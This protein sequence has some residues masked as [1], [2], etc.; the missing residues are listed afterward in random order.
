MEELLTFSSILDTD[1]PYANVKESRFGALGNGIRDDTASFQEALDT[2]G[3]AGGGFI[4]IPRGQYRVSQLIIS[5][6]NIGIVGETG[7]E[8]LSSAT[9]EAFRVQGDV[10]NIYFAHFTI[11]GTYANTD[12]K[13]ITLA[14][15]TDVLIEHM[16]I[17]DC[18]DAGIYAA[19]TYTVQR[20]TVRDN[21]I[22]HCGDF[23]VVL[24]SD[25]T[26][27]LVSDVVVSGNHLTN[28]AST[29][30][31]AHGV[32]YKGVYRGVISD[33]V[34]R[35]CLGANAS[36]IIAWE[37]CQDVTIKDNVCEGNF[38]GILIAGPTTEG[39]IVEGNT[40]RNTIG[41]RDAILVQDE[42]ENIIVA[43]NVLSGG[44]VS[45]RGI[46]VNS[47]TVR[48]QKVIVRGNTIADMIGGAIRVDLSDD[49]LVQ[50]NIIDQTGDT[51]TFSV[52]VSDST[53]VDISH[54]R[55]KGG[56]RCIMVSGATTLRS[57]VDYNKISGG[58]VWG[59]RIDP[60]VPSAQCSLIGNDGR[61]FVGT[62]SAAIDPGGAA[63]Q[64]IGNRLPSGYSVNLASAAT[65][66]LPNVV[67]IVHVTGTTP[68]TNITISW[69][70]RRVTLK[71]AT[72]AANMVV[73][74][75]NLKMAGNF[76]PDADDTITFVSEGSNWWEVSRSIN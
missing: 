46:V 3:D 42:V 47:L 57:S 15:A 7:A 72:G 53:D 31:P 49:V 52:Y 61:G 43:D 59:I 21:F 34:I 51:T 41:T 56:N 68:I 6:D 22:D 48:P 29:T 39:I 65:L 45:T 35:D 27:G 2:I 71:F 37:S 1:I 26:P 66:T 24:N 75:G 67:D 10:S 50:G 17:R 44:T 28:F 74:G 54:N 5:D 14:G 16:L 64:C 12:S 70:D 30:Y 25:A 20:L 60:A 13:G 8:L 36:A 33:N 62:A 32:Y 55:I 73:D 69:K 19:D 40:I 58:S 76:S 11:T 18:G 4:F 38:G 23:G 63:M 9:S